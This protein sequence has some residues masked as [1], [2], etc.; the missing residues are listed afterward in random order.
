MIHGAGGS[1]EAWYR[2]VPAY[3]RHF[4]ILLVDLVGCGKSQDISF[5]NNFSFECTAHQV[6]EVVDYLKIEKCHLLGLSVGCIVARTI[7]KLYPT[8]IKKVVL[9]GAITRL[10]IKMRILLSIADTFKRII[11]FQFL[12][13]ALVQFLI[14][15]KRYRTSN[16]IAYRLSDTFGFQSFLQWM[17]LL[18]R[19]HDFLSE[20]FERPIDVPTLYMMGVD[21]LVFLKQAELTIKKNPHCNT[22]VVVPNAGHG[23]NIDNKDFFNKVSIEYLLA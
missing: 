22:L 9:A 21:D 17:T 14:P 18:N 3:A 6:M 19:I 2:Q 12:K 13:W 5:T 15:Q 1:M 11:P 10:N 8:R 4:N 7:S 20:I 23:C 16:H